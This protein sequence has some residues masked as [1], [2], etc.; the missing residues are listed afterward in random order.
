MELRQLRSVIAVAEEAQFS[1]AASRLG[2]S[3][4]SLSVQIAHL[5]AE[6]GLVLFDRSSRRLQLTQAGELLLSRARLVV[7]EI[8]DV[9]DEL[10]SLRG[11]V[12]GRVAFGVT[13]T[14]GPCDLVGLL[15]GYHAL[16]PGV[17]LVVREGLSFELAEQLRHDQLDL[18]LLSEAPDHT[19][20][21]LEASSIASE[22]L[23][24][25]ISDD[26]PL[27]SGEALSALDLHEQ[28]IIS[29]PPGATIRDT[30]EDACTAVDVTAHVAVE[31]TEVTR[32]RALAAGGL[33]IGVL[34]RSD[35]VSP[36]PSVQ[37]RPL[38]GSEWEFRVSLF[39]RRGRRLSPAA[40]AL[41]EFAAADTRDSASRS[42]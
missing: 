2:I 30:I 34:P 7:S 39:R 18:A 6:L 16:Y 1:R 28:S 37:V 41:L 23:V 36:G 27:A 4:P 10:R 40:R 9:S 12:A 5:E 32:I 38:V 31:T 11:V 19:W 29:F 42:D 17:D 33:G 8:A 35:A 20:T 3:Q 22:P 24:A 21:G 25:V 14:A 15:R 26:H 13:R